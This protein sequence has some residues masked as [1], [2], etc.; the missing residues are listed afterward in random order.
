MHP[1]SAHT[2]C[3]VSLLDFDVSDFR[4]HASHGWPLAC[5]CG[6]P[7]LVSIPALISRIL[8]DWT[9]L[10]PPIG[11]KTTVGNELNL[12]LCWVSTRESSRVGLQWFEVLQPL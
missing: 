12:A 8:R 9:G 6:G 11:E 5:L 7:G 4:P 1:F 2:K 3:D 10:V